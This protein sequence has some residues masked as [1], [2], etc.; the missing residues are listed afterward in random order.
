[1]Y[2]IENVS[3]AY[4]GQNACLHP[5]ISTIV[6]NTEFAETDIYAKWHYFVIIAFRVTLQGNVCVCVC[7]EVDIL[8]HT[9]F[10]VLCCMLPNLTDICDRVLKS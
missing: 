1:M 8:M 2:Y 10:S 6:L 4:R 9:L 7:G 5:V 3:L